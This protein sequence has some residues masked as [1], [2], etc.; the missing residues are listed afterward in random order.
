MHLF[1]GAGYTHENEIPRENENDTPMKMKYL[2]EKLLNI[3]SHT[4]QTNKQT[5]QQK[6]GKG[7]DT[8]NQNFQN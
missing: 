2:Q 5:T 6:A 7:T 1:Q 3:T 4:K 8:I